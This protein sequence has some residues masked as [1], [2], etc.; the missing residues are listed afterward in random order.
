MSFLDDSASQTKQT[1]SDFRS[2]SS[3]LLRESAEDGLELMRSCTPQTCSMPYKNP[4][5]NVIQR[6][7]FSEHLNKSVQ[8]LLYSYD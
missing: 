4:N 5:C 8:C 6:T 7:A 1:W 3:V 2:K